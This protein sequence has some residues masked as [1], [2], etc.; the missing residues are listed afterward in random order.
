MDINPIFNPRAIFEFNEV[1]V[2][3]IKSAAFY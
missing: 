2:N 3:E 1:H